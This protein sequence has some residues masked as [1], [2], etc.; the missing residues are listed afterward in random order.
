MGELREEIILK[1][2][3]RMKVVGSRLRRAGYRHRM[4]EERLTKKGWET[5]EVGRKRN[6]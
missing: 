2:H 1:E 5:E 6:N 3:L 4:S